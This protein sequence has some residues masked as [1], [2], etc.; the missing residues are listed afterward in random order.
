VRPH[1]HAPSAGGRARCDW[2]WRGAYVSY[3]GDAMPCCMVATPDRI[4]FGNM[5]RDGVADV[6]SNEAYDEFRRRLDSDD[7]P[8]ICRT[9]AVYNGTF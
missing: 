2:P 1:A 9:C 5:A 4:N 8:E 3:A 6:W 7:P